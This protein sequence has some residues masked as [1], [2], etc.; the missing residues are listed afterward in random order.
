MQIVILGAGYA[1]LRAALDLDRLIREH[2]YD[3]TVTLVDQNAYH[4]VVQVLHLTATAAIHSREAIYELDR[5][6]RSSDIQFVQSRVCRIAALDRALE[7]ADGRRISYDRLVI[8]L[9]AETAYYNIPGAKEHTL[10]LRTYEQALAL[11]EHIKAQ[12]SA[13]A[14]A[15]NPRVLL[16]TA[17]V[18]GGFTGC[19]IAGEV[20]DWSDQLCAETGA[21]KNEVRIALLDRGPALLRQFGAWA[22]KDAQRSLDRMGVSVYLNTKIEAV[23]PQLLQVEGKRLLRAATVIWVAGIQAP[24]LLAESGL[25]VDSTAASMSIGIYGC[26]IKA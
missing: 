20:A 1:G 6:L 8:A 26:A 17:I 5:L 4:Q 18:G 7:L 15:A 25:E 16:T 23:E 22:G 14:G 12:F 24:A 2:G 21:P 11:R 3:A 9:G 19:Q 10:P 13:A